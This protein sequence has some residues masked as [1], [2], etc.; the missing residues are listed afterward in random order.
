MNDTTDYRELVSFCNVMAVAMKS[1]KPLPD[2]IKD[3]SGNPADNQHSLWCKNLAQKLAGGYSVAE[4]CSQIAGL[5][6]VLAR[7]LPLIGEKRL[8]RVLE[9][10]T[11]FLTNLAVAGEQ[12]KTA[13]FYPLAVSI[14]MLANLVH[15]NFFLFPRL[16]EGLVGENVSLP[17]MLR[18]LYFARPDL[19]PISLILPGVL[20]VF[21]F[22]ILRIAVQ[23]RLTSASLAARISGLSD[24]VRL[25]EVSRLQAILGL[26]L[27][28]GC[29]LQN[30]VA[31]LAEFAEG[32]DR[33]ELKDVAAALEKGIEP[34]FAFS[35][36]AILKDFDETT[37]S[38]GLLPE[39]LAFASESN[40]AHCLIFLKRFSYMMS[41]IS[42]LLTGLLVAVITSG[43]FDSY[44]WAIW[45][46]K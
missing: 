21:V 17:V 38:R 28:S 33:D 10:Y 7:L 29:S 35:L 37:I 46:F 31:T 8:I 44:Y 27:E 12:L 20:L 1:G 25:Q 11:L 26:Y 6:R 16:V 36:S 43:V 15:L 5:D 14:L 23:G 9:I 32:K 18:L 24:A 22:E 45:S 42:L 34:G 3:L 2:S 19:W 41:V 13:L 39:K 30:A 40:N 4:A